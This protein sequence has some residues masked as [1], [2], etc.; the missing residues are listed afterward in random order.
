M[1]SYNNSAQLLRRQNLDAEIDCELATRR[2]QEF[3]R[4]AWPIVEPATPFV[5]GWHIDA[6]IEHL[7]LIGSQLRG[8]LVARA[9]DVADFVRLALAKCRI[10][11]GKDSRLGA[12]LVHVVQVFV[13]RPRI[14]ACQVV[15]L[16]I[17]EVGVG[18]E[19]MMDIDAAGALVL[20][21]HPLSG[22][23]QAARRGYDSSDEF[24]ARGVGAFRRQRIR[25]HEVILSWHRG[26]V[27]QDFRFRHPGQRRL[28]VQVV[29]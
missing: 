22:Q 18:D 17:G 24:A 23:R 21:E 14:R 6:I 8:G 19:V 15:L 29:I 11:N 1:K 2:L 3:V 9:R 16:L 7:R 5:P 20:G 27:N 12:E 10:R 4:Q 28:Y 26:A 25:T 13:Q